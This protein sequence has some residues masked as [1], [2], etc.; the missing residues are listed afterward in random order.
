MAK[1]KKQNDPNFSSQATVRC[2]GWC[3]G[4]LTPR[5]LNDRY[6]PECTKK[7]LEKESGMSRRESSEINHVGS[8][9][10]ATYY[11]PDDF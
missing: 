2:L 7:K 11:P 4:Y 10:P 1:R 9:I 6:C 5:F 8:S 3:N